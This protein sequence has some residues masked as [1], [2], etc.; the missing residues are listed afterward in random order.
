MCADRESLSDSALETDVFPEPGM[1]VMSHMQSVM[2]G[3]RSASV[4]EVVPIDS[5]IWIPLEGRTLRHRIRWA[6]WATNSYR[7]N[8]F[9]SG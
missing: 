5:M 9:Q 2:G 3:I 7:A 1:P 4:P 6:E 8:R